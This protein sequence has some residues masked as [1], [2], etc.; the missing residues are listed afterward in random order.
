MTTALDI[1]TDAMRESGILTLQETPS[2]DEAVAGLS[3]LNRLV[4]NWSN[5]GNLAF[6]RVTES[7]PLSNQVISYTIGSGGDFDTARPQKI[8][9]AH[10]Q[11]G[12]VDY[13]LNI[14]SDKVYQSVIYKTIGG[15]PEML[16]FTNEFPLATINIYP[17]PGSLYTLVL[18]SEKPLTEY[19]TLSTSVSLPPGWEDALVSNLSL[20]LSPIY[21]Q[22]VTPEMVAAAKESKAMISLNALR[23]NPME[24]QPT[25]FI[26]NNIYSGF[27]T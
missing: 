1:I 10:V 23:N 11:Q 8:V 22:P 26:N 9:Q 2:N 24:N 21:G 15:L 13:A 14:V 20:K 19:A 16:N 6:E 18:T 12:S 27:G 17:S 3:R 5:T 4:R 7:F 25:G